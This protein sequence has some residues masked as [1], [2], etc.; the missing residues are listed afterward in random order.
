MLIAA[1]VPGEET[2]WSNGVAG[3]LC[4][5]MSERASYERDITSFCYQLIKPTAI[6]VPVLPLDLFVAAER[7]DRIDILKVSVQ[8]AEALV[9][10]GMAQ[11]L[12]EERVGVFMFEYMNR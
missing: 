1:H 5:M 8:G 2:I 9:L 12:Q 10:E 3:D 11:M 7:I 6:T 4:A